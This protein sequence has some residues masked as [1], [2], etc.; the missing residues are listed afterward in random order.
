MI[1]A[2]ILFFLVALTDWV[3][4]AK[5]WKKTEYAA[6]PAAMLVLF[7]ILAGYGGFSSVPLICFGLGIF[8]SLAGDIFLMISYY[9]FSNRWFIPG[10]FAFLLAHA[11]YIAGLNIPLPDVS[12][13][14]SMG[15]AI[16]L[17]L[18]AARLL[19]RI[20]AGI[21]QKGLRRLALP[22][23]SYGIVITL[24][25]LAALLAL[26]NPAWK[27]SASGLVACG[28]LLFYSSDILLAW[29]KFVKP[30]R[31]SR[32]ANMLLYH[33]GQ[34]ALVAGVILQFGKL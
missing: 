26:S 28:A 18:S 11:S 6:K 12:P 29:N 32:I 4:V 24:M 10:L 34:A 7:G 3:A 5:G 8:F 2:F 25:V 33:L 1:P 21:R 16:V 13:I 22:V 30:V 31:R 23:T 17:A 15:L 19:R 27:A 14:W 9:R 20:V